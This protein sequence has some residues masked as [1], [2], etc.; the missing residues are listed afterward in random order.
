MGNEGHSG[1]DDVGGGYIS[2]QEM[3]CC[4][5]VEDG[6]TSDGSGICQYCF[7]RIEAASA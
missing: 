1:W 2:S 5:G 3:A 4:P 6:P 7:K